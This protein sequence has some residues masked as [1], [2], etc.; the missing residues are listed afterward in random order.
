MFTD[1]R[2]LNW[3][4]KLPEQ[5]KPYAYLARIDRPIGAWLLALPGWWGITLAASHFTGFDFRAAWLVLLFGT[6]AIVMRAAGCVINDIWDRNLDK[7]VERTSVRPLASGEISVPQALAFL[8]ILL[9]IGFF[10]LISL[11]GTAILLG[12]LTIPM[13]AVY[14]LV[15]RFSYWP[16]AMLGLTFNFGALM[17]WAAVMDDMAVQATLLYLA[18]FFWTMGYD[19]IYAHQDKDDDVIVGIKSTALKFGDDSKKWVGGFYAAML[20]F[21]SLALALSPTNLIALPGLA[22]VGAHLFWQL[23]NWDMDDHASSLKMFKANR[24]LGLLVLGVILV[25]SF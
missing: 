19:T 16:Q 20:F 9:F 24:D 15:K 2:R 22:L 23:S 14:P 13:I 12:L 10:I 3:I 8:G 11:S 7:E 18:A 5:Y 21:L 6:G 4:E 25:S 17:G 1:L